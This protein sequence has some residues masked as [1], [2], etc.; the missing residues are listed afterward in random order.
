MLFY[1]KWFEAELETN[2]ADYVNKDNF[3]LSLRD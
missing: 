2:L 1:L 3:C